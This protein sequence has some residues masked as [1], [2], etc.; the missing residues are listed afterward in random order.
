MGFDIGP[1]LQRL[2]ENPA[3][4]VRQKPK[5][6]L[7]LVLKGS[8]LFM[9]ENEDM[10][11]CNGVAAVDDCEI[12]IYPPIL[13]REEYFLK[14]FPIRILS[15]QGS[16]MSRSNQIYLYFPSATDKEDWFV[17]LCR[18]SNFDKKWRR[19]VPQFM[20]ASTAAYMS[21]LI[22]NVKSP[23]LDQ[24]TQWL[25]ALIGRIFYNV[26]LS[27]PME[28]MMKAK[29]KR[30][31]ARMKRP[32]FVGDITLMGVEFGTAVPMIS[33]PQLHSM[34]ED[35]EIL[36]SCD[37][38][39]S[40]G[41]RLQI[42]TNVKVENPLYKNKSLVV[43]LV[44][45]VLV[46]KVSGRV[47]FRTKPPPSDR[48]WYGF[49]TL[50][51]LDLEM[52]PVVSS[53][54]VKWSLIT[55]LIQKRIHEMCMENI[56]LPNMDDL[57]LPPLQTGSVEESLKKRASSFDFSDKN[58]KNEKLKLNTSILLTDDEIDPSLLLIDS[59]SAHSIDSAASK[60][61]IAKKQ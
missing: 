1:Y 3:G 56:V 10:T 61:S 2:K 51:Q 54:A 60:K 32:F 7:Y 9:Y 33:N 50:P 29:F 42:A 36:F 12:D 47:L 37:L 17:N 34:N 58:D 22:R 8:S 39:Y 57:L 19:D 25:N 44:L 11:V 27:T 15:R 20:A 53:K 23:S 40:G 13:N 45:S 38:L 46:K 16:V 49:Y 26:H 28:E 30:K 4:L 5:E 21:K 18:A 14:E 55:Q 6:V 59:D 48:L 31:T 43:D 41:F 35:G 52:E 24:S